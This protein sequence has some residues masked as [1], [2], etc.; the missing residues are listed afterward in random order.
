MQQ[1]HPNL[2]V[3]D[4]PLRFL[5]LEVGARMTVVRLPNE[6]LLLHSPIAA[7]ADLVREVK[8]LGS[9]AYLIAPNRLH[10]LY[11]GEWKRACP[12]ASIYVAPGLETKRSDLAIEAVLTN[13][14][15]PAWKEAMDQILLDGFPFS[16]EVVFFHRASATLI[17]TDLAF[18]VGAASPPFTR[19]AVRFGGTYGELA[20]TLL[21]RLLVRDRVAFRRSF[22]RIL[23]WPFGRVVVAHG[24]VSE[25]GGRE[26]LVAGYEWLLKAD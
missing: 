16:N 6:K 17:A 25:T 13:D 15:E 3:T 23:E 1:L 8:A 12:D 24:E 14:P 20:P 19:M 22:E 11:I 9:V 2:W 7:T 10:H 26:E 5:G 21:E 4:A 18:N